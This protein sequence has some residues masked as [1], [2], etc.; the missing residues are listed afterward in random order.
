MRTGVAPKL[1]PRPSPA[2]WLPNFPG[3]RPAGHAIAVSIGGPRGAD[4]GGFSCSEMLGWCVGQHW[5]LGQTGWGAIASLGSRVA[6]LFTV[7][8]RFPAFLS[9][10]DGAHIDATV[11]TLGRLKDVNG[12][13]MVR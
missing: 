13:I 3:Y 9:A 10:E 7:L 2:P 6:G 11:L 5:V 4:A 1:D 8:L 12:V